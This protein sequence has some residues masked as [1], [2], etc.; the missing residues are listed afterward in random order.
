[1]TE[2]TTYYHHRSGKTTPSFLERLDSFYYLGGKRYVI[3]EQHNRYRV[4]EPHAHE[5]LYIRITL[6]ALSYLTV[7]G[8][9]LHAFVQVRR[10]YYHYQLDRSLTPQPPETTTPPEPSTPTQNQT[11]PLL[12]PSQPPETITLQPTLTTTQDQEKD[13]EL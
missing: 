3:D 5:H 8:L 4:L 6:I 1:M 10:C 7:I 13:F 2:I 11:A 12:P 9:I